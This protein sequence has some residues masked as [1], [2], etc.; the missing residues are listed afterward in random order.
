MAVALAQEGSF[1]FGLQSEKGTFVSPTTWLPLM[2]VGD[3]KGGDLIQLRKNYALLDLAD[4][5]DYQSRY[6]SAGEWAEGELAVPLIPGVLTE[7]FSWLQDR[8]SYNQGK[9][10]SA[11]IDCINEVKK[12][13]DGTGVKGNE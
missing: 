11:V 4:A 12:L 5:N 2:R 1:G 7:L 6:Y 9:W 13:T 10:G 8:D 3:R